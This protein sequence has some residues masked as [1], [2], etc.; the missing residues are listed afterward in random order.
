MVA[1]RLKKKKLR[2]NCCNTEETGGITESKFRS[3]KQF[4]WYSFISPLL[5]GLGGLQPKN[6]SK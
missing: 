5:M 6:S 4:K 1:I 3:K 2:S